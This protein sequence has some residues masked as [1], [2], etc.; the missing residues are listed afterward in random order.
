[1][2]RC[3]GD[4]DP[5]YE[6]YH[7]EEWGRPVRDERGLFEK[8]S[9]EAFQSGLSWITILR[10]RETFRAAFADFDPERVAAYGRADVARLLADPGIIRN[11]AKVD[12]TIA[13]A[14]ATL[15]LRE[16]DEPLAELVWAHRPAPGAGRPRR[17]PRCPPR[18]RRA[19]PW[20]GRSSAA[21][22][23]SSARRRST[24]SCRPAAWSTTISRPAP[25]ARPSL[26]RRPTAD[27]DL[28]MTVR[29]PAMPSPRAALRRVRPH[30]LPIVQ[31]AVAAVAAYYL[32]LLLP[33][34]DQR[35]VFASIAAVIALGVSYG[36]RGR[37][38]V[39]LSAGVMLGLVVADLI[40]HTIGTGPLQIGVVIVVAM[41]VAVLLRGGEMV[42]VESAVS[43]LLLVSL[44]PSTDGFSSTRLFE[45]LVGG[46]VAL[47]VNSLFFPP[48]PAL[49]ASR[50]AHALFAELGGVL[51]GLSRALAEG[52][53]KAAGAA[54]VRARE[55]DG[56]VRELEATLT[57][58]RET[59]RLSP[60]RR[61][62]GD[63]LARY[64]DALP[65]L[66]YALRSARVLARHGLRRVRGTVPAPEAVALAVDDLAEA[67]LAPG[68]VLRRPRAGR[69]RR[70]PRTRRGRAR[71][72]GLRPHAGPPARRGGQR[73]PLDRRRPRPRRRRRCGRTRNP[74]GAAHGRAARRR[75]PRDGHRLSSDASGAADEGAGRPLRRN[76][77]SVRGA[78]RLPGAGDA[79]RPRALRPAAPQPQ[80]SG[81][82]SRAR[83][84]CSRALARCDSAAASR[85]SASSR[86]A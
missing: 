15:A 28:H 27:D 54:L 8:L 76:S 73:H 59:A 71:P 47:A 57:V 33:L 31:T 45:A 81:S 19:S 64:G 16:T 7:D 35:P 40:V 44:E 85:R 65:H 23:G 72:P 77:E 56:R 11:R 10:R 51:Q 34:P 70:L 37:R 74:G 86:A 14:R 5:L 13:N 3:F 83:S 29:T 24:R 78:G 58:A 38:A 26:K 55:A 20:R 42:I 21:A 48:D 30:A 62:A 4:G 39:E 52:D 12:A 79:R 43:A 63:V 25:C 18:S 61:G 9:L 68:R 66:D 32:A 22:F 36:Q 6:R 41:S 53:P 2:A 82:T 49:L 84:A 17:S 1:M 80:A 60:P 67:T 50:A 46:G 75:A 69:R